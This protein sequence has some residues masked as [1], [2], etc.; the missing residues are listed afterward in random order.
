MAAK[1]DNAFDGIMAQLEARQFAPVY[2][3]MGEEPYYID[4]ISDFIEQHV[5]SEEERDFNQS[6]VYGL[7]VS[8]VQVADMARRYPMMAEYQVIIVKEAQNIKQWDALETYFEKP[9][10]QTI[11]VICYKNG[12]IDGRKKIVSKA[13]T[14]GIVFESKKMRDYE[15]SAFVASYLKGKDVSIDNKSAQMVAEHIGADLSRLTSEL[16]KVIISLPEDK[17]EITPEIVER[18]IGVSKDYNGF[19]LRNAIVDRNVFKANQ[20]VKYFAGNPKTQKDSMY[21]LVPMLF[22]Y[23]QNLMI[24]YYVPN[25]QN[26]NTLA[27]A[28]GLKNAW[29]VKDYLAGMRNYSAT[30]TMQIISRIRETDDKMKGIGNPNTDAGELIKELIFFILH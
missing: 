14:A 11:L 3:L 6:I 13:R 24:A 21:V 30:K 18:E 8:A 12:T 15:L 2:L 7:D 27:E 1:K 9:M 20:I 25:N 5:L 29:G 16:D 28:L 26:P 4:Q 19:E 17:R 10:N 22:N 23:F